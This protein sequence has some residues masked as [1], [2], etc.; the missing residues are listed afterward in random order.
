MNFFLLPTRV[1]LSLERDSDE[2][3][4][5]PETRAYPVSLFRWS[6]SPRLF[7]SV[8][9]QRVGTE[10]WTT[11]PTGFVLLPRSRSSR[12]LAF[13]PVVSDAPLQVCNWLPGELAALGL[14]PSYCDRK[15]SQDDYRNAEEARF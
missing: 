5:S 1:A 4:V 9:V 6:K 12:A 3:C 11:L 10:F 15:E 13:D 14:I 2:L 7:I 8:V